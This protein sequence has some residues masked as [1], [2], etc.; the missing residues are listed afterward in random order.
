MRALLP[1]SVLILTI[2]AFFGSE[3]FFITSIFFS[4]LITFSSK[5]YKFLF[6]IPLSLLIFIYFPLFVVEILTLLYLS[7]E[8]PFIKGI[9]LLSSLLLFIISFPVIYLIVLH[10][11]IGISEALIN[12]TITSVVAATL[13]TIIGVV[14]SLP[15]GYLMARRE[16]MG[17]RVIE[18]VIDI[19]IVIP[20]T[21]SGILLLIVF[22]SAGV[23]GAPL[24]DL[25]FRFY[26]A[27]PGVV[28]AML[29]VSVPF[30]IN[31]IREGIEKIDERYEFVAMNLG[32]TRFKAF[33][34]VVLPLIKRNAWIGSINAWAR[35]MS[36]FG[37]VIMIAFYPMVVP[38]YIYFLFSNYGLEKTL[39]ATSF[40]VLF[41][42]LI[43]VVLRIFAGRIADVRD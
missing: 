17:K 25:G 28:L 3:A 19:P 29:F 18:G 43:F 20:H 13:S 7:D 42:L 9:I 24:E 4:V 10:P 31:Q 8:E 21:V 38:T 37:A 23:I 22:G 33:L 2:S 32:A 15:L 5:N 36:E 39:P 6:L 12:V 35:A 1:G 41:T 27:L 16:F 30:L 40:I 14:L 34:T 26:Y 11:P